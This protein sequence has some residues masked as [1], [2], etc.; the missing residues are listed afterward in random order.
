[1]GR[2]M[3]WLVAKFLRLRYWIKPDIRH[4]IDAVG[5]FLAITLFFL[6]IAG[7]QEWRQRHREFDDDHW[8]GRFT[9]APKNPYHDRNTSPRSP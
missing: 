2:E 5:M 6:A 8:W 3:S 9:S 4:A 7:F 1:M